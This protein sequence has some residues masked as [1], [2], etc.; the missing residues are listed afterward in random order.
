ML[1]KI[2]NK[3]HWM[4]R[5][6][7]EIQSGLARQEEIN[8][9]FRQLLNEQNREVRERLIHIED[10]LQIVDEDKIEDMRSRLIHIED[11][12]NVVMNQNTGDIYLAL[13]EK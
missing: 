8:K 3:V 1:R 9:E 10:R 5:V 4:I 7:N 6:L 12:V 13:K 11:K 2:K